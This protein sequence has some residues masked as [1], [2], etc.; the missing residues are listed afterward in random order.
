[1]TCK[2]I[3]DDNRS[4]PLHVDDDTGEKQSTAEDSKGDTNGDDDQDA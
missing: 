2:S 4:I 1:M 3:R